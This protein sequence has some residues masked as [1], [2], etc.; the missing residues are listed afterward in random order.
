MRRWKIL[1]VA[2]CALPG[3]IIGQN[4]CVGD[5]NDD[6]TVNLQDILLLLTYYGDSCTAPPLNGAM[7]QISEI[8]YNPN[9]EQG[10]DSDWEFLE[11]YNFED[12]PVS[13][14]DWSL[15]V[16]VTRTFTEEDSIPAF[17]HFVVARNVDSLLTVLPAHAHYC[18]WNSGQSLNNNGETIE[19]RRSDG[20]LADYVMYEDND[21][22]VTNPDGMGP[23][24]EWMDL[25]LPNEEASSWSASLILG[26]TPG[27]ANSMWGLSEAE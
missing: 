6:L 12:H 13:L 27:E 17:G 25:G 7:I 9:S 8:H 22:W 26:G 10:N 21:G 19:L 14:A 11:L 4:N 5:V 15:E 1:G 2:L 23:S 16:G 20:S 24:L 18:Q 3:S